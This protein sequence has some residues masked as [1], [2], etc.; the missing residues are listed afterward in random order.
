[1]VLV[2]S[3]HQPTFGANNQS[4]GAV[5]YYKHEGWTTVA[6]NSRT[7]SSSRVRRPRSHPASLGG[8][9][10]QPVKVLVSPDGAGSNQCG[11]VADLSLIDR[12]SSVL[13]Q[14]KMAATGQK[15]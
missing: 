7:G 13:S 4:R 12:Y 2:V 8:G 6:T 3:K 9:S 15:H 10:K 14:Y 1:M 5:V 11:H